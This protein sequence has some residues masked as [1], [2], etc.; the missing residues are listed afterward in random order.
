MPG[1]ASPDPGLTQK[2]HMTDTLTE[3]TTKDL[4]GG[5]GPTLDMDLG[6]YIPPRKEPPRALHMKPGVF[7]YEYDEVTGRG[8]PMAELSIDFPA[9]FGSEDEREFLVMLYKRE[10][11]GG[12][13]FRQGFAGGPG[14]KTKQTIIS[15]LDGCDTD[16]E[17]A[18]VIAIL[19]AHREPGVPDVSIEVESYQALVF[20]GYDRPPHGAK[21]TKLYLRCGEHNSEEYLIRELRVP[22]TDD[23]TFT[24]KIYK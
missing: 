5:K 6:H 17:R 18:R 16:E 1:P 2:L 12:R 9:D 13:P 11:D 8:K 15:L 21:V 3:P 23:F 22:L 4:T 20:P 14:F 19:N 24:V 7:E 10:F